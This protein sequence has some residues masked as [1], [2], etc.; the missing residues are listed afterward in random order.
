MSLNPS[1]STEQI[2]G[3]P[4]LYKETPSQKSKK[5]E[6]E[7]DREEEKEKKEEERGKRCKLYLMVQ[8]CNV[9][10]QETETRGI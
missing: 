6:E 5:N 4:E 2:P 10:A 1:Q 3:H 9:R 7:E 8:D